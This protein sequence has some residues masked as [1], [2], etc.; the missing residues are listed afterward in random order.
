MLAALLGSWVTPRFGGLFTTFPAI[1]LA[2]L[3]LLGRKEG[4]ERASDDAKGAVVGAIAL[5]VCAGV[6]VGLLSWLSGALAL[7]V[8]LFLWLLVASL[9]YFLS[10]R[11]GWLRHEPGKDH[12]ER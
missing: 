7:G 4:K 3:T 2:S 6:L 1:L 9:L 11:K 10:V 12:P 8:A 5:V